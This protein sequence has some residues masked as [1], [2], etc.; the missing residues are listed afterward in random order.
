[1]TEVSCALHCPLALVDKERSERPERTALLE[2]SVKEVFGKVHSFESFST[3]DGPGIRYVVFAQG[4]PCR[5][6]FCCNPD[7]WD[8]SQGTCYSSKDVAEKMHRML[9]FMKSSGGG[10][11]VSG[12]EA[13]MQP[14]FVGALFQ[15][16]H[17][18]GVSTCL[19]TSA[20]GSCS[21]EWAQVLDHTDVVLIC[22]KH[23]RKEIYNKITKRRLGPVL[24]FIQEL[25]TREIPFWIRYVLIPGL[26][27]SR[28][29][30]ELLCLF[31]K[32]QPLLQGI[33]FLPY[34]TLGVEKW[35]EMGLEYPL[36]DALPPTRSE[37]L[38]VI[39]Q[40]KE[41]GLT[42]SCDLSTTRTAAKAS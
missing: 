32:K 39:E 6:L 25:N 37:V 15:E 28:E 22:V 20:Q 38:E 17:E 4:C 26:T 24:K 31:C 9:P 35:K 42:I 27:M 21:T 40:V 10:I 33:E 41:H 30:I 7:T 2:N 29:D 18:M 23:M 3:V 8:P 34:H 36:K 12:G 1:M 11:T 19:D 14:E 16:A 13:M 5:C